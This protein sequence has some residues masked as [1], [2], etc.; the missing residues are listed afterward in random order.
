MEEEVHHNNTCRSSI[1]QEVLVMDF[2][3]VLWLCSHQF[4]FQYYEAV[5]DQISLLLYNI[6]RLGAHPSGL[7]VSV[8]T[9]EKKFERP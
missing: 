5:E 4:F 9:S 8:E 1:H 7:V 3:E 6:G 2:E